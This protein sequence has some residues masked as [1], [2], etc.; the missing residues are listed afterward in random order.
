MYEE[1]DPSPE[2]PS[3]GSGNDEASSDE[4]E[5]VDEASKESFPASD[6][7]AYR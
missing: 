3:P 1:R 6:P 5:E 4:S 2:D 7:P